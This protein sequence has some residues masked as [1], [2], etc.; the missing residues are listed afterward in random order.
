MHAWEDVKAMFNGGSRKRLV[1]PPPP[2]A[3]KTGRWGDT[4]AP[5][6]TGRHDDESLGR[7]K[8]QRVVE[9]GGRVVATNRSSNC[10]PRHPPGFYVHPSYPALPGP[11]RTS[12]GS[13]GQ[14]HHQ[15]YSHPSAP[16]PTPTSI[17]SSSPACVPYY[18]V[19]KMQMFAAAAATGDVW[20]ARAA[21]AAAAAAAV[22]GVCPLTQPINM[23]W[24]PTT[25]PGDLLTAV[26]R[27][28][29]NPLEQFLAMSPSSVGQYRQL[30]H[31]RALAAFDDVKQLRNG[32]CRQGQGQGRSPPLPAEARKPFSAFRLVSD[33]DD[34][35]VVG[36]GPTSAPIDCDS[37]PI[38]VMNDD[39]DDD[40]GRQRLDGN[41]NH[42]DGGDVATIREDKLVKNETHAA[43]TDSEFI[44][45]QRSSNEVYSRNHR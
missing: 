20:K 30:Q 9:D 18:D 26:G 42:C 23:I 43:L 34:L 32:H 4:A 31:Q 25:P 40:D 12:S 28:P 17:Q 38:D 8:R 15:L 3:A 7:A 16:F 10:I 19:I 24:P 13:S 33:V 11:G 44:N 37:D 22:T 39:D 2:P 45:Q 27:P 6:G 29:R 36:A 35:T 41:A 1:S 21:A 14:P 5:G